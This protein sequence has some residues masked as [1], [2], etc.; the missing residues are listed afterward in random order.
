MTGV[1]WFFV[2]KYG[3]GTYRVYFPAYSLETSKRYTNSFI[4]QEDVASSSDYLPDMKDNVDVVVFQRPV[5]SIYIK[6]LEDAK[7]LGIKTVVE[8]DDLLFD[9]PRHNP[10][11]KL[12]RKKAIQQIYK[13][14]LSGVDKVI[15][16][17]LPLLQ[18]VNNEMSWYGDKVVLCQN[19][20]HEVAWSPELLDNSGRY[21]RGDPNQLIIGWQGSTT[22]EIDFKEVLPALQKILEE[23]T[24]V[25]LRL[26]G[27]I[28]RS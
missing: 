1:L 2:D 12:W 8:M 17:T 15:V 19:H 13:E 22:H 27:D 9:I 25:K 24:N 5:S 11:S 26:F 7:K 20:L 6:A 4:W 14:I 18:A 10:A 21:K 16:S 28:P 23:R 3:C